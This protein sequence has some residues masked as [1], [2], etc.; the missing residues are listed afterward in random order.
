MTSRTYKSKTCSQENIPT[1][2]G[3][4][5]THEFIGLNPFTQKNLSHRQVLFFFFI[6]SNKNHLFFASC[7]SRTFFW[8]VTAANKHSHRKQ[9]EFPHRLFS[10]ISYNGLC[11]K[12][13]KLLTDFH[14]TL[15]FIILHPVHNRNSKRYSHATCHVTFWLKS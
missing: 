13:A 1:V 6:D 14:L 8:T 2:Y 3:G 15:T 12:H 9:T 4:T 10:L 11:K 7:E 5:H